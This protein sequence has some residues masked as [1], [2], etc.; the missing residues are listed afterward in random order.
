[1]WDFFLTILHVTLLS[2][3]ILFSVILLKRSQSGEEI[4]SAADNKTDFTTGIK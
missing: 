4:D 2:G 1:M 3:I